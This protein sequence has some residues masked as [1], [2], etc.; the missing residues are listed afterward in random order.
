MTDEGDVRVNVPVI[1]WADL[2][3]ASS[4]APF[5]PGEHCK[6]GEGGMGAV[7][8]A[9]LAP[10]SEWR[11]LHR[12]AARGGAG[13]VMPVAVKTVKAE[14]AGGGGSGGAASSGGL[15]PASM[16]RRELKQHFAVRRHPNV[17]NVLGMCRGSSPASREGY[18]IVMELLSCSLGDAIEEKDGGRWRALPLSERLRRCGGVRACVR[19]RGV[20]A[21]CGRTHAALPRQR[22]WCPPSR[23]CTRSAWCM[24]M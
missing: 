17:V 20:D 14:E 16:M 24:R 10:T 22:S 12:G 19:V 8:R 5:A 15:D 1:S 2:L 13:T 18:A 9:R 3:D 6:L 21:C 23:R 11:S 7:F 4:S